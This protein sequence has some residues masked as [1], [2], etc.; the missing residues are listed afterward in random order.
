MDRQELDRL[1]I[2]LW[3]RLR[4]AVKDG[5]QPTALSLLD[6]AQASSVRMKET[7][8]DL[9]GMALNELASRVGEEAI[10]DLMRAFCL[11]NIRP[12]F[13]GD[14]LQLDIDERIRRRAR[15]FAELH[16]I[17]FEIE[18]DDEKF[19]LRFSCETGGYLRS[20]KGSGTTREAHPWS[21]GSAGVGYYCTHCP[22]SFEVM[23]IEE[24]GLPWWVTEPPRHPGE[25]C[26]QYHY[27][28]PRSVP[29][30]YY[31]R[32]GLKKPDL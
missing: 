22:V 5:D 9:T 24:Y 25:L 15:G 19:I 7:I 12:L 16:N 8:L 1:S 13:G 3:D 6:K 26:T 30:R 17:P 21:G 23:A 32:L 18:E 27:K 4:Q 2:S 28:D 29:E 11:S 31:R 14:W 10:H 20:R